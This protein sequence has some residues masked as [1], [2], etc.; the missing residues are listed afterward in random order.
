MAAMV[1]PRLGAPLHGKTPNNADLLQPKNAQEVILAAKRAA[2]S[3]FLHTG[4][5]ADFKAP[6]Q[7]GALH[8]PDR[9][10]RRVDGMAA[11]FL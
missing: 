1:Q 3:I 7:V 2:S 6:H 4:L 5:T 10:T 8:I 11:T 9:T